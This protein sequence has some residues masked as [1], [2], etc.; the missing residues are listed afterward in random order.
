M[1]LVLIVHSQK[2]MNNVAFYSYLIFTMNPWWGDII[3]SVLQVKGLRLGEF[4]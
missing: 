4:R 3:I 1:M 2:Y